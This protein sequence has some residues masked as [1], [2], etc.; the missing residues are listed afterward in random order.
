[1]TVQKSLESGDARPAKE[2]LAEC[3]ADLRGWEWYYC[4]RLCDLNLRAGRN[5]AGD[6]PA[7]VNEEFVTIKHP[8][9]V[10]GL[11]FS[12]DSSRLATGNSSFLMLS[13]AS[14]GKEIIRQE[15]GHDSNQRIR[16]VAFSPNGKQVASWSDDGTVRIVD[17]VTM[18]LVGVFRG[19]FR[20]RLLDG[21][22]S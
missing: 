20:L 19:T 14:T 3:P 12:P 6:L 21:V 1:M 18:K 7:F 8:G 9:G 4:Q 16:G 13:N 15:T 5:L 22:Q 11:A 10:H 17:A 2:V